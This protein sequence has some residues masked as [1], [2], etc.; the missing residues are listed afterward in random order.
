M[1][2]TSVHNSTRHTVH[3]VPFLCF[4][5]SNKYKRSRDL[6]HYTISKKEVANVTQMSYSICPIALQF[7]GDGPHLH[8]IDPLNCCTIE[9]IYC[10][11]DSTF[12]GRSI[13]N[14]RCTKEMEQESTCQLMNVKALNSSENLQNII[15]ARS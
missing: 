15:R 9:L 3:H 11:E 1:K 4:P 5:H 7:C 6:D 12:G 13:V 10:T 2:P 8:S 14:G